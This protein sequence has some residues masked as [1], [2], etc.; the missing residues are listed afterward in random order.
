MFHM[1]ATPATNQEFRYSKCIL[2][3]SI[4][5]IGTKYSIFIDL[6]IALIS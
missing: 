3:A 1:P 4:K 5:D 6:N 2:F